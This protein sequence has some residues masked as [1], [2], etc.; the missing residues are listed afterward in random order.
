MKRKLP[1]AQHSGSGAATVSAG[2]ALA[3]VASRPRIII[4]VIIR[5]A[6]RASTGQSHWGRI[7][8]RFQVGR[9]ITLAIVGASALAEALAGSDVFA[10]LAGW[11]R[12]FRTY[13]KSNQSIAQAGKRILIPASRPAIWARNQAFRALPLLAR[14]GLG[15]V[16]KL[17]RASG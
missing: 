1:W 13:V 4:A 7:M 9:V 16:G 3:A 5:S 11:E 8:S 15:F 14:L 10:A 12:G 17:E 6:I 2:A